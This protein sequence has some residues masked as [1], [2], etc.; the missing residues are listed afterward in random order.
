[1]L[2]LCVWWHVFFLPYHIVMSL[3]FYVCWYYW[4]L[5]LTTT[6]RGTTTTTRGARIWH[7][8]QTRAQWTNGNTTTAGARIWQLHF[9]PRAQCMPCE[10]L[11]F[12]NLKF[13]SGFIHVHNDLPFVLYM[14]KEPTV[15]NAN[16]YFIFIFLQSY[17][18]WFINVCR[19]NF[20]V[21]FYLYE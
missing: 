14:H 2:C 17:I 21:L 4:P 7:R 18:S 9:Q 1:M 15:L 8:H 5:W 6:A 12:T 19:Y 13:V 3:V 20:N 10:Y 11:F 16:I